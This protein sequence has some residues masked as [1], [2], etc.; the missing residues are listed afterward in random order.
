[1]EKIR[2]FQY[3]SRRILTGFPVEFTRLGQITRGICLNVSDDGLRAEMESEME[4]G[5]SGSLTLRPNGMYLQ[6]PVATISAE[7]HQAS[8]AFC[9]Q[10]D[11][12]REQAATMIASLLPPK[13]TNCVL[14]DEPR[15]HR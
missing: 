14:I 6:I 10:S 1:M 12:E 15:N 5:A 13:K 8:F 7:N 9:F 3:R 2:S 11:S 4:P